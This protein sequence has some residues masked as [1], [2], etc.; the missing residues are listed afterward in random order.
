MCEDQ[1]IGFIIVVIIIFISSSKDKM[2]KQGFS[3]VSL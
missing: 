2:W 1:Q 3:E